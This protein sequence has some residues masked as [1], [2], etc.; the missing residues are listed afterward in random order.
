MRISKSFVVGFSCFLWIFLISTSFAENGFFLVGGTRAVIEGKQLIL[1]DQ[2][3]R[4]SVAPAGRYDT[5]DGKFSIVV[6]G[7]GIVV[8]DNTKEPR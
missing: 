6:K 8:L 1:I 7:N 5:R 3:S 4:R 2:N